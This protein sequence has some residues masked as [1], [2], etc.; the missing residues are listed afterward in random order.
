MRNTILCLLFSCICNIS[1]AQ[2]EVVNTYTSETVLSISIINKHIMIGAN[3]SFLATSTDECASL[4]VLNTNSITTG[5]WTDFYRLDSMHIYALQHNSPMTTIYASK[6]AGQTWQVKLDT[7]TIIG[8]EFIMLDSMQGI[9][10]CFDEKAMYTYDGGDTW[11]YR[12]TQI[13]SS[14]TIGKFGDSVVYVGAAQSRFYYS[15]NRGNNWRLTNTGT[16]YPSY[17]TGVHLIS[18]DTIFGVSGSSVGDFFSKSTDSG[19][20]WINRQFAS[21]E[22]ILTSD[23][24]FQSKLEGYIVGKMASFL[25]TG[26]IAKTLDGGQSWTVINTGII[27]ALISIEFLNDSIA[28][29]GGTN[30]ILLKWN[31]N[32]NAT[33]LIDLQPTKIQAQVYP[34]PCN[35]TQQLFVQV[36]KKEKLQIRLIDML[37]R[38]LKQVYDG[39]ALLGENKFSINLSNLPNGVYNYQIVLG[40][41]RARVKIEKRN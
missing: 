7:D 3:M 16:I 23:V 32:S 2:L 39:E 4:H 25:D 21:N 28:L 36:A 27:G 18:P 30:G 14:K 12:P 29:I 41:K 19:K 24:Y 5:A 40:N 20:T 13:Y 9:L 11:V 38:C 35:A 37:G 31:K 15:I 1:N 34:N 10:M 6:D 8:L 17:M 26:A 33:K 22:R